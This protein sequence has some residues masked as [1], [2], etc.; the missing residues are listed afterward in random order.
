MSEIC[1]KKEIEFSVGLFRIG[2]VVQNEEEAEDDFMLHFKKKG[3]F[4]VHVGKKHFRS[5]AEAE[6]Y[7]SSLVINGFSILDL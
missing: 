4:G 3:S 2:A 1:I 6:L 5:V 7:I